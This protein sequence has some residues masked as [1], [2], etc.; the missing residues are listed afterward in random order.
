MN[1]KAVIRRDQHKN[2]REG[3]HSLVALGNIPFEWGRLDQT[4]QSANE[5][6]APPCSL[7]DPNVACR[8]PRC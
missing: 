7:S 3:L 5:V 8:R 1:E 2:R 4:S 6:R